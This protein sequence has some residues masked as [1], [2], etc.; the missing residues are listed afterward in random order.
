MTLVRTP[1][2]QA[3]AIERAAGIER[4]AGKPQRGRDIAEE[5]EK[6]G[7]VVGDDL[8]AAVK[9]AE[10]RLERPPVIIEKDI[11]VEGVKFRAI[12]DRAE[13]IGRASCRERVC[14]YV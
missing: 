12:D 14:K 3:R 1:S 11:L 8:V 4:G 2:R 10:N 13:Q 9:G 5:V 6:V 7:S